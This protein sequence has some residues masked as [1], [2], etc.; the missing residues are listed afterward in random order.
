MQSIIT[1]KS[2][3]HIP[4]KIRKEVGLPL[5]APVHV[6]AEAGRVIVEPIKDSV[7]ALGGILKVKNPILVEEIRKHIKYSEKR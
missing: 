1:Q 2:Q 6:R 3:V 5:N 4:A 7:L